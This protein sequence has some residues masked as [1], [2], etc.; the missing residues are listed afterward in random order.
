MALPEPDNSSLA[1]NRL[2]SIA[3]ADPWTCRAADRLSAVLLAKV[4]PLIVASESM[5]TADLDFSVA[6]SRGFGSVA[7][8]TGN[9]AALLA[10][11]NS[12]Q[13]VTDQVLDRMPLTLG[14]DQARPEASGI[15]VID[16]GPVRR[17]EGNF[18]VGDTIR[19]LVPDSDLQKR[20]KP[21]FRSRLSQRDVDRWTSKVARR[22]TG[23]T[24]RGRA[25]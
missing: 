22:S 25:R 21:F 16:Q 24:R 14:G 2:S 4:V 1:K 9:Q 5:T 19:I 3:I 11:R 7:P 8:G 20:G 17:P 18:G 6:N 15:V 12:R 10:R 23:S 13:F